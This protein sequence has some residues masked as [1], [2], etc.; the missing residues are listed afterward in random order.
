MEEMKT[1]LEDIYDTLKENGFETYYPSQ[2]VGEC[3]SEYVVIKK[4][5]SSQHGTFKTDDDQYS[6]LCYVPQT[7]YGDLERLLLKVK[8]TMKKIYP[9]VIPLGSQSPS[10]YDELIKAHMITIYYKNYKKM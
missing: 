9:R 4:E 5:G 6:I 8:S 10:Y 1:V 2:K 7:R 3:K